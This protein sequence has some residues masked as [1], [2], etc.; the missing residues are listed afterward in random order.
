TSGRASIW[1]D[2]C[3]RGRRCGSS[4][5]AKSAIPCS[6]SSG[7]SRPCGRTRTSRAW[8]AGHS[9]CGWDAGRRWGRRRLLLAGHAA[10]ANRRLVAFAPVHELVAEAPAVTQH[11][12]QEAHVDEIADTPVI[13]VRTIGKEDLPA[14]AVGQFDPASALEDGG[15]AHSA[16]D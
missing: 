8:R 3:A 14:R 6:T 10:E 1:W 13:C 7:R 2:T 4:S 11:D 12:G 15:N 16:H 5:R 9:T